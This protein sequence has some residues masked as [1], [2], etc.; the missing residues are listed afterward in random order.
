MCGI[1]GY[2][3]F[4]GIT[5]EDFEYFQ[6]ALER[7]KKRGTQATGIITQKGWGVKANVPSD[8]LPKRPEYPQVKEKAVGQQWMIGHV[9][10]A[11]R[12][13][14][15]LNINNHPLKIRANTFVIHNGVVSSKNPAEVIDDPEK[16]DSYVIVNAINKEW[17]NGDLVETIKK[18]YDDFNGAA[19]IAVSSPTEIVIARKWNPLHIGEYNGG[20]IFASEP[21]FIKEATNIYEFTEFISKG[22]NTLGETKEAQI[23]KVERVISPQYDWSKQDWRTNK[24]KD[25][26]QRRLTE[27]AF[28]EV[29]GFYIGD[30][31]DTNLSAYVKTKEELRYEAGKGWHN[32]PKRHTEAYYKG[33]EAK[34]E[35]IINRTVGKTI[36]ELKEHTW[37]WTPPKRK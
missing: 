8:Q 14:P 23:T 11:T 25:T 33:L 20:I 18:A 10:H 5:T 19:A 21:E 28:D 24:Q 35:S 27:D 36:K 16:T 26:N 7:S 32:E 4:S 9:R 17:V 22:W 6:T 15:D 12:G 13:S 1:V 2:I 30:P 37:N 31:R 3:K 34:R 29:D